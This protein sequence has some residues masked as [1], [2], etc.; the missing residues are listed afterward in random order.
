[1]IKNNIETF[2]KKVSKKCSIKDSEKFDVLVV[3]P[4]WNQ[5][6]TG[7]RGVRPNQTKTLDYPTLSKEEIIKLPDGTL[8]TVYHY[9][10]NSNVAIESVLTNTEF[11]EIQT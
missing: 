3:D 7:L 11:E 2:F 8:S 4:P 10:K 5:G 6:K 1:M 9:L